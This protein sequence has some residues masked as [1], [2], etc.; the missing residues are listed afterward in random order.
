MDPLSLTVVQA[1]QANANLTELVNLLIQAD[2]VD[3]LSGDGP[4]TVF[5]PSNAAFA[6]VNSTVVGLSNTQ[7]QQVLSYHVGD[8]LAATAAELT[9]GQSIDTLFASHQLTVDKH[10]APPTVI[11]VGETNNVSVSTADVVCSNGVVHIVDGVLIPTL[12]FDVL[13]Q[14]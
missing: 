14:A 9:D 10:S 2:L 3:A 11:L 8:T 6:A 12:S 7:L 1:A 13:I 5:A 4:F